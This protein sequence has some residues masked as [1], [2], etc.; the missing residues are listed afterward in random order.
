M[1]WEQLQKMLKLISATANEYAAVDH[2]LR[3]NDI[4]FI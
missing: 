2:L 4:T 1:T 3:D